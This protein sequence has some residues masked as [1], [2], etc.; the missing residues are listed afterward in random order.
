ML[1]DLLLIADAGTL[2]LVRILGL[3]NM[4]IVFVVNV[5]TCMKKR[6]NCE[7]EYE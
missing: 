1:R 3:I 2:S 5:K 4:G 7:K 6:D